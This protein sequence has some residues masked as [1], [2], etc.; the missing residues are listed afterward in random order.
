MW[1]HLQ[2]LYRKDVIVTGGNGF[3]GKHVC[4]WLRRLGAYPLVIGSN[5]WDM[6]QKVDAPAEIKRAF[7]HCHYAI[8]LAGFN[9]GIEFNRKY[10]ADIFFANTVMGLNFLE[11]CAVFE[12]PKALMLVA[13]CAYPASQPAGQLCKLHGIKE[14]P[15]EVLVEDM[16]LQGESH[17]TVACH[18]YAKRNL[19]LAARFYNQQ[20]D[21]NVSCACVTTLY[22]PGDSFDPERTKFVGGLVK[23]FVDA[24]DNGDKEVT[25]W[26]SGNAKREIIYVDDAARDLLFALLAYEN[27]RVPLNVGYG[28]E[29]TIR[30]F[31]ESIA[32]KA[33]YKGAIGWDTTKPDGQMRKKLDSKRWTDLLLNYH[34]KHTPAHAYYPPTY[35]PFADGI[36]KTIAWYRENRE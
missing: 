22:G 20:Y 16:F 10:P 29:L 17:D 27:P 36:A 25:C 34:F 1:Q 13:S 26:G 21:L 7:R 11:H 35:T 6:T 19:Q 9:G 12:V 30:Q 28:T 15:T 24:A 23:R 3:L 2:Q 18:G 5:D 33:G 32:E 31:A 4:N 8:H 14:H